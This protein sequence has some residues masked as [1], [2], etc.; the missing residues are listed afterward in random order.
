MRLS[1]CGRGSWN[2]S[3]PPFPEKQ[4]SLKNIINLVLNW[5]K[6]MY[7]ATVTIICVLQGHRDS[8]CSLDLVMNISC[9]WLD[10]LDTAF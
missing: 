4:D 9:W 8:I 10:W 3:W 6:L 5:L 1:D 7:I 2:G